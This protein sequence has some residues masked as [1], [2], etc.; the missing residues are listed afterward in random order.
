MSYL[1]TVT[2]KFINV[3]DPQPDEID[4]ND[5]AWGL[6]RMPRFAGQT[7][8]KQPYTVAQHSILVAQLIEQWYNKNTTG[9]I[10]AWKIE[11]HALMGLL[12]DASE[13][14]IGD[15][16]S[17]VKKHPAIKETIKTFEYEL[18]NKI[19]SKFDLPIPNN[20]QKWLI[21][22]ADMKALA[23]E[24][25]AFMV[26]RGRGEHWGDMPAV[27][28]VELQEFKEPMT[29]IEAYTQFMIYFDKLKGL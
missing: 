25:H 27:D 12:H 28:L 9:G 16:P 5:I 18:L 13:A 3:A 14:Y 17:P 7:I 4:I 10:S 2:G 26:S 20:D 6:S 19:Y 23:L 1:E 8:T 11:Q 21:K 22:W 29:S 24:A 15:I